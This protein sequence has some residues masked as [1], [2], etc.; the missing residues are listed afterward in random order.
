MPDGEA[1]DGSETV[2]GNPGVFAKEVGFGEDGVEN[3]AF[4]AGQLD[5]AVDFS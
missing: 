2:I 3:D 1:R 5:T 4:G